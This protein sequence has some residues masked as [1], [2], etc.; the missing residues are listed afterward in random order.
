[1]FLPYHV[2]VP[3]KR[4]P[5]TNWI[6]IAVTI[7]VSIY[8][9]VSVA[10]G[11]MSEEA[12]ESFVLGGGTLRSWLVHMLIHGGGWHLFGNMLFLFLF[13]NAICAKVGNLYYIPIY[14]GMGLLAAAVHMLFD[15]RPAIGASGA[16]NGIVG[17]FA[18]LYPIN[19]VSCVMII[20]LIPRKI[21]VSSIWII[22]LWFAFDILGAMAGVGGVAHYAHIGGLLGGAALALVLLS[23]GTVTPGKYEK[24]LPQN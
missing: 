10:G 14:I 23:S 7:I 20:W 11:D 8:I 13:G 2:D 19:N 12:L 5:V 17:M 9:F 15:G 1:M 4:W 21:I 3:M 22:L 24:T 18:V 6:L 16:I